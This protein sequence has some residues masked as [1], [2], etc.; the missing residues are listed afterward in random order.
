MINE[1]D[2][3]NVPDEYNVENSVMN[4]G[5][6]LEEVNKEVST[7]GNV[8]SEPGADLKL[9]TYRKVVQSI[10]K[11]QKKTIPILGKYEKA[12]I[13]GVRIQQ[14]ASGAKPCV[15]TTGMKSIEEIVYAELNQRAMP[16]IIKRPLPNGTCEYWRLEEFLIV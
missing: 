16:F 7:K 12:R 3:M 11:G 15:D 6:S 5:N 8:V 10:A 2:V 13:V 4:L 9:P 14:L 1:A